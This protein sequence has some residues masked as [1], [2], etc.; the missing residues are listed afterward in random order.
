VE[1]RLK[2]IDGVGLLTG[3]RREEGTETA[4]L[5]E[6]L[7]QGEKL[8]KIKTIIN[9]TTFLTT[10]DDRGFLKGFEVERKFRLGHAKAIAQFADTQFLLA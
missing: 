2:N 4:I 10:T 9:P 6:V 7:F 8:G 1:N 3:A 5:R